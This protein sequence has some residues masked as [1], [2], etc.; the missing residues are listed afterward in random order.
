MVAYNK[1]RKEHVSYMVKKPKMIVSLAP[2]NTEILFALG[3]E[4]EV[5]GVTALCDYPLLVKEK[6]KAG[7]ISAIE[8]NL[9][10]N[11]EK[12]V[13]L[14]PDLVLAATSLQ[15]RI[16]K[17]LKQHGLE[18]L[19]L[20]PGSISEVLESIIMIGKIAGRASEAEDLANSMK[21]R[22]GKI[23]D[24]T[25][26]ATYRPKIYYEE[27]YK[28]LITVSPRS[29][30]NDVIE[31]SGGINLFRDPGNQ[32][33]NHQA[34]TLEVSSEEI[35]QRNPEI[36]A[37]G[38]CGFKGR[39]NLE[40]IKKRAGWNSIEAV[41]NHKIYAVDE[42]LFA[43]PGPRIVEGLELLAQLAHPELFTA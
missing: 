30:I 4:D 33:R 39:V 41:R 20:D 40:D 9:E 5:I 11:V 12:I 29:Y 22:I 3:L 7:K 32:L 24:K 17:T 18:V 27:W 35:I 14:R 37:V 2:S 13:S 36:I 31:L 34:R 23:V 6:I 10:V 43:R 19:L 16:A 15:N 26:D 28:P 21:Q 25:R 42:S 8:G 1:L 38:W